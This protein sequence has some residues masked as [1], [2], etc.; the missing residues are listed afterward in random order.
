MRLILMDTVTIFVAYTRK[1][2]EH[3]DSLLAHISPLR[4]QGFDIWDDGLISPGDNWDSVIREKLATADII[5]LL[6]SAEFLASD[7]CFEVEIKKAVERHDAGEAKVIPIILRPCCWED[8]IFA[9][10]Q[11]LPEDAEPVTTWPDRD[12]VLTSIVKE[13]RAA[14]T[15]F[16]EEKRRKAEAEAKRKR[17][18]E[19]KRRK[20]EAKRRKARA[21]AKRK[22]EEERELLFTRIKTPI[23]GE[24]EIFQRIPAGEFLI[25]SPKSEEGRKENEG[26]QHRIAIRSP[27]LIAAVP[28]T[29]GQYKAFDPE[30][31]AF[32]RGKVPDEE[33]SY[34]PVVGTSLREALA[35][36]RWLA[37]SWP[38]ARGARLPTEEEWEYACRAGSKTRYWSGDTVDDAKRVAWCA[39]NSERRTHRVG[40][41]PANGW[42]LYDM[43]GNVWERTLSEWTDDYS[44]RR[45]ANSIDPSA[46]DTTSIGDLDQGKC[47]IRGGGFG[48]N[49]HAV[50]AAKRVGDYALGNCGYLGFRVLLPTAEVTNG[51]EQSTQA[52]GYPGD[53]T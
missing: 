32:W 46:V 43:H 23:D 47:V 30:H 40:E 37:E 8:A 21:E 38:W 3:K 2:K 6:V 45:N 27:F 24:V 11:A 4:R 15:S 17:E 1:D 29:V 41:K 48:D 44:G 18:A 16:Q 12:L 28:V 5:L 50:R 33:L 42:G 22:E 35:F 31:P 9:K 39:D 10:I 14:A 25:G 7:Y 26:P 34:H 20:A 36:C 19:A 53:R 13:I 52:A 49:P 51:I